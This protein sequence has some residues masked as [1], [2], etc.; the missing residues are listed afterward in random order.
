MNKK[1]EKGKVYAEYRAKMLR[2]INEVACKY[3]HSS[4]LGELIGVYL[5][6]R[7]VHLQRQRLDDL[8]V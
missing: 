3:G 5:M 4:S 2:N 7:A 6:P 8:R 1:R